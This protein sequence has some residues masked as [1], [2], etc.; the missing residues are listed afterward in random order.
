MSVSG[1]VVKDDN[2]HL[3]PKRAPVML[4]AACGFTPWHKKNPAPWRAPGSRIIF[5]HPLYTFQVVLYTIFLLSR[6]NRSRQQI[7]YSGTLR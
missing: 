2:L 6:E 4:P 1:A 3:R 7:Q 5:Q